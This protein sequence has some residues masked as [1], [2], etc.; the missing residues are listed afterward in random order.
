MK[1][2][3]D[4]ITTWL[5]LTEAQASDP[6]R[7]S[8]I[9]TASGLEVEGLEEMP[10]VPGGLKGMVVGEVLTCTPHP[11]ADR[12]RIT[13]VDVGAGDPLSIVCGAP[14]V[15]AGQKVVVATVGSTCHPLE[16]EP[17][18]IKKG[19]I[20]GEVSMGMICAE[21]ELGIGSDHDG[22][23]VLDG[24]IEKGTPA[25]SALGLQSDHCIEI[26]LTPNRTDAMGHRGVA[27]DLRAA[28]KWNGGDGEGATLADLDAM[29]NLNL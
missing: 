22:I 29:P 24:S 2:S 17:F 20:R 4:W 23:L 8:D 9:L 18:K 21:D 12:L 27:R 19:K 7:V 26:G 6:Q 15:A 5:P 10:A 16:G 25:A 13:T 11:N 14:N 1:V 3:L 28:W